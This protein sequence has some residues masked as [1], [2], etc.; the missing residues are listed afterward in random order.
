MSETSIRPDRTLGDIV[1]E[2]PASAQ[3]FESLDIDYCC[4]GNQ[5]LAE[6]CREAGVAVETVRDR[7]DDAAED[8]APA[9][10]HGSPTEI[11]DHI[12]ETHHEPLREELPALGQ[13]VEK[14]ARVHGQNHLEL[15]DVQTTFEE[16][17]SE[18]REHTT[19]EEREVF[20]IVEKLDR[21]EQ[22]DET[23]RKRLRTALDDLED[24]H[25]QTAAHLERLADLTDGYTAP[26]DACVSY[27]S[28]LNRLEALE[29]DTHLHV[30]TENNVLFP[31]VERQ[32]AQASN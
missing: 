4:G 7:L 16:L 14:V 28:M 13:L 8:D 9:V 25:D 18:M 12:V 29:A 30:H 6:A 15:R 1:T 24:D 3:V 26:E 27:R 23:E 19:E 10:P 2:N 20:P 22:L 21:G 11:V 17:A 5:T 32:L 31:Q